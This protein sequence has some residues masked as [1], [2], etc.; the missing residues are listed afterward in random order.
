[1]LLIRIPLFDS[2]GF[3]KTSEHFSQSRVRRVARPTRRRQ[4]GEVRPL[5]PGRIDGR[6]V[7]RVDIHGGV[8][9]S[10]VTGGSASGYIADNN[11]AATVCARRL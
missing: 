1:L 9:Y 11:I 6:P 4:T 8:M 3:F 10:K 2:R 7:K 5:R